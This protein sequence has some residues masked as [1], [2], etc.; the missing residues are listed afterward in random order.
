M[1]VLV[2]EG[3]D[4]NDD[5][6]VKIKQTLREKTSPRHVPKLIFQAPPDG[7]PYTFSNKKV[8][9]AVTKIIHGMEVTNRGALRNPESLDFY[10]EMKDKLQ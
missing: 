4:L 9:I 10:L 1:F 8:E 3:Y 6:K 7:I 2:N 5:L